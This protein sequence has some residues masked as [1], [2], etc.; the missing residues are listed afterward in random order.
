M[1][2]VSPDG[3]VYQGGTLSG[4]PV[5]MAAGATL[6][7]ELHKHPD[8]YEELEE[9]ARYLIKGLKRVF[10]EN[11]IPHHINHVGSMLGVFYTDQQ[12]D[13]FESASSTDQEFFKS[14]FHGM[15]DRG[16]YLP[17]S[18]FECWFLSTAHTE[19]QLD[20]TIEAAEQTLVRLSDK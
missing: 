2:V 16:I 19:S 8:H 11:D 5:A 12:V 15:L 17:P 13:D 3:P 4:N 18:P 7:R 6:L 14:F 1:K 10:A 20:Q 9:K